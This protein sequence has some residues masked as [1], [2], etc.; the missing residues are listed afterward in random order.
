MEEAEA[1]SCSCCRSG[2]RQRLL[3]AARQPGRS[4]AG[5]GLWAGGVVGGGATPPACGGRGSSR[6]VEEQQLLVLT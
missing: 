5:E 4:P 3:H 1:S 2:R 6:K